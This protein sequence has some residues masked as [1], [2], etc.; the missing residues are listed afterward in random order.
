M[1]CIPRERLAALVDEPDSATA[2]ERNCLE[3]CAECQEAVRELRAAADLL[4]RVHHTAP[5]EL[6]DRILHAAQS[7]NS[8]RIWLPA[9]GV[10]MAAMLAVVFFAPGFRSSPEEPQFRARAIGNGPTSQAVF[11]VYVIDSQG[12]AQP[13]LAPIKETSE[14]AFAY[15]NPD[16]QPWQTLN[17]IGVDSESRIHALLPGPNAPEVAMSI[18]P[19]QRFVEI[20]IAVRAPW[21]LGELSLF[22]LFCRGEIDAQTMSNWRD[23]PR[24]AVPSGCALRTHSLRVH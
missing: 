20:P 2:D 21:S 15:S 19:S 4:R 14:L 23:A 17:V 10:A 8:R 9:L 7:Q 6:R 22:G 18:L 16:A 24:T 5:P 3:T 11:R 1:S 12:T 13:A